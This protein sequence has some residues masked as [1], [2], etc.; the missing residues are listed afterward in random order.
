[1]NALITRNDGL[2]FVILLMVS[3]SLWVQ[4]YKVFKSL[5]PVLTVVVIGIILSNTHIVPIS[6]DL[7]GEISTYLV[8]VA[9]S[10]CMLSMNFKELKKLTKEPLLALISA[11]FSVCIVAIILGI[12]FAPK[13][14]EGWKCAGMFVGTYTGGTP[15]LTAIATGLDCSRET[16]AA[17]NAADYVVSTPL[18]VFLFASPMILKASKRWNKFWPYQLSDEEL[19][20]GEQETLM[21]D[22]KWS[23][24]DITWLLTIGFAVTF[25]TTIIS[26]KIF[27]ADFWKSGRLLMLTTVSIIISQLKPVK[28]L[29]GNLD[30]GLFLSLIFLSTIGFAVDLKQFIGSAF[31][32]TLYVLLML[33]LC[34]LVHLIIC[35][36][37]KIKY[38]YVILS[39]VGCIVDGPT[40]ALTAAGANWKSLINVGLIMGIIAGALGNY[41]GIFVS[42]T[43]KYL[44]GI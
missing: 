36:L 25:F 1:M 21:S 4:K 42:Y 28:K 39:M 41:V 2:L 9:I 24:K 15:N 37:L 20:D 17:A 18:M 8:P 16:L 44:C 34:I 27:P 3:L 35:R 32:M 22:K 26:Q 11:I 6:H 31:M 38:E 30:L 13:I 43:V 23:I 7:Y 33:I 40:S 14:I 12:Y 19:E 29:R 10:V 5:G